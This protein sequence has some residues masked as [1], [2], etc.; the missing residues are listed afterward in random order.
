MLILI[1][2]KLNRL[3]VMFLFL[4][5][6]LFFNFFVV[7]G[8]F[9]TNSTRRMNKQMGSGVAPIYVKKGELGRP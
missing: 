7:S 3:F 6:F 2:F 1:N 9:S 4:F 8:F 5:L